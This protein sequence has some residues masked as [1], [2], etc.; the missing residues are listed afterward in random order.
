M[1][2]K[3]RV[4]I[5]GL[6]I[7]SPIGIGK[8][9][10]LDALRN[11]RSGAG[12]VTYF[13]TST[14][15]CQIDAE[16]KGFVADN[17][18]DKKKVRRMDRFTQFAMAATKMA[19]ADSGIDF[20]KEDPDRC[21]A[22]VGSGI[23][24]LQTIEA[25]HSVILEKGMK[26]VSPFLIPMLISNIAPG[27]IAIEYGLTGPN[28]AVSSACATSNHAF[29]AALRHMRYGDAD[30]LIAGG[31]EAAITALGYAGFCQARALTSGFN[32]R[33]EKASRPFDKD[34]SGFLMGEG[35]GIVVLETLE[36]AL[37]RNAKIYGE[38]AGFGATDD[39]YHITAP[40][41]EA[42]AATRAM[43]LALADA[44]VRPEEVDYV[45]AHG[46]ST[47]LNDKTETMALKKVFGEHARK[48]AVSSTKSMTGHL[49]GA[50]GAA[51][52]IA[53][54]LCMEHGFIHPTINYETPDPD[55]D[56]DYVPNTARPGKI[57]CALS[58][59]L[60][61][62]GHNAVIVAKRYQG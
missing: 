9:A 22:I 11:G 60:G 38:L 55:C 47:E 17:F 7:V 18:M 32:D 2:S 28:Y 53:T 23:G 58:N 31:A 8:E 62:G 6:G 29:G 36:H 30:V 27:E 1:M 61:F 3:K 16:V 50:A 44:G 45:N 46:T 25:E 54:L 13:D 43:Q 56:L 21:G 4:V 19:V 20:S 51:E 15:P 26:R 12:R 48:L 57:M 41:P 52:L 35:A 40:S 34:R 42:K 24:G 5:T 49:L 10:Y 39:A 14:Y 37:A 33:P 59:S